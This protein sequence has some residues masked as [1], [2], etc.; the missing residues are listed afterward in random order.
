MFFLGIFI[1]L[2][3]ELE[4]LKYVKNAYLP[5]HAPSAGIKAFFSR[6]KK[7][8]QMNKTLKVTDENEN[9]FYFYITKIKKK[10]KHNSSYY[11]YEVANKFL[12]HVEEKKPAKFQKYFKLSLIFFF[13]RNEKSCKTDLQ[14]EVIS[15]EK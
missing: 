1:S 3:T 4:I 7:N 11:K 5:Q 15:R 12:N 6:V 2:F 13:H 8:L 14:N 10:K 9:S